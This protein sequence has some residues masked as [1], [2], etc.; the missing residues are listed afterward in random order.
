MKYNDQFE[1]RELAVLL[2]QLASVLENG[3]EG[4][5]VEFGCY[6]GDT[7]VEIQKLLVTTKSS[8]DLY[9]YDSFAGLPDKTSADASPAGMQFKSGELSASRSEVV[10]KFKRAGL[11]M[12]KVY[13]AWFSDLTDT[14][15]PEKIAFAFLDG[16]YYESIKTS[17]SLIKSRLQ[18]GARIVVDD[19]QNEA[20]PGAGRAVDEWLK[21]NPAA[22]SITESLAII[23]T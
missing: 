6:R 17:L 1:P 8:K 15:L 2:S 5:I 12:P 21:I 18:P 20:L 10:N 22:M 4:D 11:P 23:K 7:S 13:K 3:V 9:L 14:Q 19:Y 16:D